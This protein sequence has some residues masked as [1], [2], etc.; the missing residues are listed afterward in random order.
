MNGILITDPS[1]PMTMAY[2]VATHQNF[3]A[4]STL[5]VEVTDKNFN[6]LNCICYEQSAARFR[7]TVDRELAKIVPYRHAAEQE[8]SALRASK[9][10]VA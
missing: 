7:V 6:I 10:G 4:G 1:S 5:E 2:A 3:V 8:L 9:E